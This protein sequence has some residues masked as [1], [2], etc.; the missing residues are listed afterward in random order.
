V[1]V[2]QWVLDAFASLLLLVL[3]YAI[4]LVVRRWWLSRGGGTF[5]L[6]HRVRV[7]H[8]GR[9]WVLGIGRY[10]DSGLEWYRIFSLIPRPKRVWPRADL[11]Y[12]GRRQAE[13]VERMSLYPDHVIVSCRAG[14][15]TVELAMSTESLTGFQ[16][17]LEAGPPGTTLT[18]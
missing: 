11:S 6:S 18:H 14:E 2:W 9:G 5:E 3:I 12:D 10:T 15:Q 7:S 13:G 16:A 4:L 1:P 17:W 8:A